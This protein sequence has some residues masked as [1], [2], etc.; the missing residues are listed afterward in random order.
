MHN[1]APS[2]RPSG[3]VARFL[4]GNPPGAE[5]TFTIPQPQPGVFAS[6]RVQML[7]P[8]APGACHSIWQFVAPTGVAICAPLTC[9]RHHAG[10]VAVTV[11]H[12]AL[13]TTTAAA[14]HAEVHGLL[15]RLLLISVVLSGDGTEF[16][17]VGE[18][19]VADN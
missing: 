4:G 2:A 16:F 9:A 3:S 7:V 1:L 5:H 17:M 10:K 6:V 18:D 8:A 13:T 11:A 15:L 14:A 12:A 19:R